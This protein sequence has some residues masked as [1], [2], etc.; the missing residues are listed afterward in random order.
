MEDAFFPTRH[1][2]VPVLEDGD[3]VGLVSFR[4][5][6]RL[7]RESWAG[8]PVAR[9]MT[10]AAEVGLPAEAPLSQ[11]LSRL[12]GSG[13]RRALVY[14]DGQLAGLLSLTDVARVLE[15]RAGADAARQV[16]TPWSSPGPASERS[17]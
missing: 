16:A 6:L 1:T 8:T 3:A 10:A 7:P 9:I 15:A 13:P 17:S 14:R 4:Q 5:A 12:T 11:A 2:A